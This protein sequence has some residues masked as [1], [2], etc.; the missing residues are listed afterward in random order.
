MAITKH[1]YTH[2][3]KNGKVVQ[4]YWNGIFRGI[5]QKASDG[6]YEYRRDGSAFFIID[7]VDEDH[8]IT[9]LL[10]SWGIS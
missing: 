9:K 6:K 5:V 1:T 4:V 3:Q 8:A 7:M 2:R 10:E